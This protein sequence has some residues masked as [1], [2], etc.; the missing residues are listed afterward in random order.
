MKTGYHAVYEKDYFGAIDHAKENGFEFVQFDLNVPNYYLDGLSDDDLLK[1]K[2]YAKNSDVEITFHAPGDNISL[3]CDYPYVRKGILDQLKMILEKAGRLG[4]R[5]LTIH[6]GNYPRFKKSGMKTD[7]YSLIYRSYYENILYENIKELIECRGAVLICL[8]N[9]RF[10][11]PAMN[12]AERLIREGGGLCLTL[13][14]SKMYNKLDQMDGSVSRFM[15]AYKDHI[16]E[17]HIHDRNAQFGSHQIF[18]TGIVDFSLFRDIMIRDDVYLNFEVRP[19][20]AAKISKDN[21]EK[22]LASL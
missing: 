2:E 11:E 7:E 13:D 15:T 10:D 12:A 20:E 19:L 6:A 8:E 17:M 9:D 4:A 21:F 5:H 14:T 18:G 22:Y 1:I 3:Y 16:R